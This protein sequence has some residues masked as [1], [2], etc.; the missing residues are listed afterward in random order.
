MKLAFVFFVVRRVL[1]SLRELFWTHLLTSGTM[2]MTLFVFGGFLLIQENLDGLLRGWSDE[3]QVFAYLNDNL[4]RAKA[5]A[6]ERLVVKY[7]E[8]ENVQYIS[9]EDAWNSFQKDL[10]AQSSILE[11]LSPRIFPASLEISIRNGYRQHA[12][13]TEF[14][15]RL[16]TVE[17]VDEVEYP[18]T[19]IEKI[20]LLIV[21]VRWVKWILGGFLFLVSFLIV[22]STV[23]LAIMG[24]RDE[25]EIMQL[26][27]ATA[28]LVKAPFVLEG[29][30]QGLA[31]AA[32]ALI[33]L[34]FLFA[35]LTAE[36]LAP[37]SPL[38]SAEQLRFL[39]LWQCVFL[40]S[41]GWVLGMSG[42]IFSVKRFLSE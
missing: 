40:I 42:S 8:V 34:R 18:E 41:L 21:G 7:P 12:A 13:V 38:I 11:G 31:G 35:A 3:F 17:G 14:A 16:M 4:S 39:D 36:F 28:G 2:A 29:T 30:I 25:I 10:G 20:R 15:R 6:I 22:S 23:K 37:F 24:R 5:E 1:R 27:G 32:F 9:K 26:V 33:L 19:W